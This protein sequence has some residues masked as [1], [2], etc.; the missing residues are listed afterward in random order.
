M[1][2][3]AYQSPTMQVVKIQQRGHLLSASPSDSL[4]I[5]TLDDDND[6]KIDNEEGVW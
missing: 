2:K 3:K 5:Y 6:D 1:K 4:W